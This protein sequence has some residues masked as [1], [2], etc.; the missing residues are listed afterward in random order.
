METPESRRKAGTIVETA[1][2][3]SRI[4]QRALAKR[5]GISETWYRSIVKGLAGKQPERAGDETWMRLAV[6][7]GADPSEVFGALGRDLPADDPIHPTPAAEE[8]RDATHTRLQVGERLRWQSLADGT[9]EWR[10]DT[11]DGAGAVM[12]ME[13]GTSEAEA[14]EALRAD[15]ELARSL[16]SQ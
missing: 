14:L 6:M 13:A 3:R 7:S 15:V 4:S 9:V 12:V 16:R 10:L 2:T 5:A 1:R 8:P 11:A